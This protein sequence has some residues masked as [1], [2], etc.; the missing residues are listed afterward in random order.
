MLKKYHGLTNRL[1]DRRCIRSEVTDFFIKS[2]D[3]L[4]NKAVVV[5]YSYPLN[6]KLNHITYAKCLG[7]ANYHSN[8]VCCGNSWRIN[9]HGAGYTE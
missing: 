6:F 9:K 2:S 7:A 5:V 1:P 8:P 4:K 3:T